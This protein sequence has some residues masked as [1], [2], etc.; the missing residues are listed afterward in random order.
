MKQISTNTLLSRKDI[1]D[2]A[3]IE[4]HNFD[5]H[6]LALDSLS[7]LTRQF[8]NNPDFDELLEIILY[9]FSGQFAVGSCFITIRDPQSR[10]GAPVYKGLGKYKDKKCFELLGSPENDS[11]FFLKNT[12]A[13]RVEDFLDQKRV[14]AKNRHY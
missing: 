11:G 5:K 14:K 4:E 1:A 3:D 9:T 8:A 13:Y 10:V 6:E 2:I 12:K 7:K